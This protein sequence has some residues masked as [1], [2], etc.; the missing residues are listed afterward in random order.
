MMYH[1]RRTLT[2][3]FC[4]HQNELT[5]KKDSTERNKILSLK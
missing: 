4:D 1:F 2:K 3:S 5:Q